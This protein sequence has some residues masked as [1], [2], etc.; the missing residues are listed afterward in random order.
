[1]AGMYK[2]C[3]Y[4]GMKR[5]PY[6][7]RHCDS[8]K[9]KVA[10][11]R[12]QYKRNRADSKI[13]NTRQWKKLR[14]EVLED[15]N[16]MCWVCSQIK[17]KKRYTAADHVHHIKSILSSPELALDYNNCLPVC[18]ECHSD[19][20]RYNLTSMEAIEEHFRVGE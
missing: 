18:S 20:H 8:C 11:Q 5:I 17:P 19:I 14:H 2:I 1:M 13:Y 15:N 16:H 7:E 4:C 3:S 6:N 9:P 12:Q 10:K